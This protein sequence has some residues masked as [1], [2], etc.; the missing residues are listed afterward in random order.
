MPTMIQIVYAVRNP[1]DVLVSLYYFLQTIPQ[2]EYEGSFEDLFN[3]FIEGK[4]M[5]GPWWEHVNTF[6]RL[7]N[8]YVVHYEDMIKVSYE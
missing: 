4:H 3:S 5:C 8:V 2:D 1:K 6:T 7:E